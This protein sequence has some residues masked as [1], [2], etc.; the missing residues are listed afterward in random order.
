MF[1]TSTP[2][3]DRQSV[4][5]RCYR[6][7]VALLSIA[8][9]TS[10]C[11]QMI[12]IET[13]LNNASSSF[14][15]RNGVGFNFDL[16]G[17][18]GIIGLGPDGQPTANGSIPFR[19]G[20]FGALPPFGGYDP[21]ADTTF[22]FG[23]RGRNGG[24]FGLNF[25]FGQGSDQTYTSTNPIVVITNGTTGSVS[26]TSQRPFVTSIVPV[27]GDEVDNPAVG[28]P[29]GDILDA[30]VDE[31]AAMKRPRARSSAETGDLSVAELRRQRQQQEDGKIDT[32]LAKA[33]L[34]V[35]QDKPATA[36][37]FFRSALR[38]AADTN[39]HSAILAEYEEFVSETR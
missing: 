11:A 5:V 14:Y 29:A 16:P 22:G 1:T 17:S 37:V 19:I 26:D 34:A 25:A 27:L 21:N 20:G 30:A 6:A 31:D 32:L 18:S 15:E 8:V 4:F 3:T 2:V 7:G 28:K 38:A 13:P 12:V 10:V 24:G 39:R 9:A 36:K 33:R 23:R 35:E